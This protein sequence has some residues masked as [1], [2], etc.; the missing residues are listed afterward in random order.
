MFSRLFACLILFLPALGTADT[1]VLLHGYQGHAD[2]WRRSGIVKRLVDAGW[3][4][5]G[6]AVFGQT[7]GWTAIPESDF[8]GRRRLVTLEMPSDVSL[9]QQAARLQEV[10]R[11]LSESRDDD[12]I[13]VGHSA[14]GV[15]AR[16]AIVQGPRELRVRQLITVASPHL[17]VELAGVGAAV[18]EG[19]LGEIAPLIGL[20][21]LLNASQLYRDL[22]PES[23][24][25]L[26]YR[27]NRQP[28][29][30]IDYVSLVRESSRGVPGDLLVPTASQR[31]ESVAALSRVAR[32]VG[33]GMGH[34][35]R[36]T[37][38][39]LLLNAISGPRRL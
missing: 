34:G 29:P 4:D 33:A 21:R 30:L 3:Q 7:H 9:M 28:H 8:G 19:P 12:L 14:G 32:S 13:L 25:N 37:D 20:G 23:Q 39:E 16:L 17:G 15:V 2:D 1:L 22:A 38:A 5:V 11:R 36:S 24:G 27:L 10:L 31:M 6:T 35:L 26:L 18:A